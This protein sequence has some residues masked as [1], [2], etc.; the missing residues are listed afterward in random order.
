M[1]PVSNITLS[2]GSS[3][4]WQNA[5]LWQDANR[6]AAIFAQFWAKVQR[7]DA[8]ACW[9]WVGHVSDRGYGVFTIGRVRIRAH[10]F[11][12]WASRGNLDEGVEICHE[13]HNTRCVNPGHL[14]PGSHQAN[15][16]DSVRAGRKCAW[17]LQK[18][19][20]AQVYEIRARVAAGELQKDVAKAYGVS[21]NNVCGIVHRKSWAHLPPALPSPVARAL[22][23]GRASR[24][25]L[26]SSGAGVH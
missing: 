4:A 20:A 16:L 8:K 7:A 13:C 15:H 12:Y 1:N 25:A 24:L 3:Y 22:V 26:R 18:L 6:R 10:R 5:K 11:A 14:Y 19:N 21:R 2:T 23:V 9:L 17:G